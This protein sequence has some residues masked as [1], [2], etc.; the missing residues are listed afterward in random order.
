M[1]KK[2]ILSLLTGASVVLG[3]CAH[4][5]ET[6]SV[7]QE[8]ETASFEKMLAQRFSGQ[9][10]TVV[11]ESLEA[12]KEGNLTL[13]SEKINMALIEQPTNSFLHFTNGII[14]HL[15]ARKGDIS[16]LD[17][18]KAGFEQA[19]KFNPSNGEAYLQ[20]ARIH[21]DEKR[22][23]QAQDDYAAALLI[24]P[25]HEEALYELAQASYYATDLRTAQM[26][27]S[28]A[29]HKNARRADIQRAAVMIFA[30]A[31]KPEKAKEHFDIYKTL[32]DPKDIENLTLDRVKSWHSLYEKGL[33]VAQND[34][35]QSEDSKQPDFGTPDSENSSSSSAK[36]AAAPAQAKP[37]NPMIVIDATTLRVSETGTTS[38]GKNIL[39]NFSV[40][41]APGAHVF[42]RGNITKTGGGTAT[43]SE[44]GY[45]SVSGA[46]GSGSTRL[47]AQGIT[48]GAIKYSLNIANASKERIEIIGRPSLVASVG[49]P[50]PAKFFSGKQLT[51]GLAPS[52]GGGGSIQ[53]LPVG[54]TLEVT[55]LSLEE[56]QVTLDIAMYGSA[57]NNNDLRKIDGSF[58]NPTEQYTPIN[59]SKIKTRVKAKLGETVMLA[60]I[61]ERL[62]TQNKAGVPFLQDVPG[63]Q[64]LFSEQTTSSEQKS[65]VYLMTL[66]SYESN[67]QAIKAIHSRERQPNLKELEIR[68]VDWY[69]PDY[70]MAV[71]LKHFSSLYREFRHGDLTPLR[72]DMEKKYEEQVAQVSS[73]LYY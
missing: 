4:Q 61:T 38:K 67:K 16:R 22:Y 39:E 36:P 48:F 68:N 60:G 64:Y 73:F 44:T 20:L 5:G 15:M 71:S 42:A 13:A 54:I 66:R 6:P 70:N 34:E 47:F 10:G 31:G 49:A 43:L 17:L 7:T 72:W 45:P 33:V 69:D 50:E 53:R 58:A 29:L 55:P 57:V 56:D 19:I 12:L 35:D 8:I 11:R 59:I 65:V 63:L 41:L 18:A 37:A 9:E 23:Q 25:D 24:K 52:G 2:Y 1:E 26:S 46:G 40:T 3:G 28:R 14:Y 27:I 21:M 30:A 32:G 62:E 51:L